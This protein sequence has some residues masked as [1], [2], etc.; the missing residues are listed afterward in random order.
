VKD[1][2]AKHFAIDMNPHF[3][4]YLLYSFFA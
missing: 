3:L 2:L 4:Y 1:S